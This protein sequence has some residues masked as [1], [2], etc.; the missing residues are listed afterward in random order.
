MSE[1]YDVNV[2][3]ALEIWVAVTELFPDSTYGAASTTDQ[4]DAVEAYRAFDD[5]AAKLQP[6]IGKV[7]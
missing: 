3:T 4:R 7:A 1:I 5:G 2:I 6:G